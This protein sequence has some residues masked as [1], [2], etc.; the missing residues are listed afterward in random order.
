M[1]DE[2]K[3][4]EELEQAAESSIPLSE[5]EAPLP[6]DELNKVAGGRASG[7]KRVKYMIVK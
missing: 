3:K 5:H 7:D 1:S 4:P 2:L 6:E